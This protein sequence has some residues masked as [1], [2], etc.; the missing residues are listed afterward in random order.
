LEGER[1][2]GQALSFHN[3]SLVRAP[4][5]LPRAGLSRSSHWAPPFKGSTTSQYCHLGDQTPN[6]WTLDGTHKQ[7]PNHGSCSHGTWFLLS[8][9]W[10]ATVRVV[11]INQGC[12]SLS[13]C[14]LS[15]RHPLPFLLFGYVWSSTWISL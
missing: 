2:G 1:N 8:W 15:F 12:L 10:L 14:D 4:Q 9:H 3:N 6:T 11:F 13:L 5:S 7:Y